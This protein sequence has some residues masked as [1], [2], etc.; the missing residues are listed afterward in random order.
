[1]FSAKTGLNLRLLALLYQKARNSRQE[2]HFAERPHFQPKLASICDFW[3]Y[4]T[5]KCVSRA[6]NTILHKNIISAKTGHNLR[7]LAQLYEKVRNSRQEHDFA[8]KHRF[9]PKLASI[10]DF[11]HYCTKKCVTRTRNTILHKNMFSAKTG[12]NLRFLAQLYQ[13]V[14]NSRYE[15]NFAQKH[16]FQ[17]KLAS[18]CDFW[19]YC[20]KK[21]VTRTRNTILP[22]NM[23]S[24]K[25]WP[26][27][28]I[29]GTIV[30]KSA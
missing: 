5:K 13:K 22:K 7:F 2:Q 18:I 26:Q 15:Q 10:S 25:T 9:Q 29:S 8:Q 19:H 11:W 14:R 16:R 27:Y 4:C 28:A 17:P 3:H 6:R 23:F 24:A 21:C 12:L 1:M 30:P 20:T